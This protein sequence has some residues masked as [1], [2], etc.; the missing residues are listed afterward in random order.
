MLGEEA[1]GKRGLG[2]CS[3][4]RALTCPCA[5]AGWRGGGAQGGGR[6]ARHL[7]GLRGAS[8][9]CSERCLAV[10]AARMAAVKC[11]LSPEKCFPGF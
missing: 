6:S 3:E 4:A 9:S 2:R 10:G 5:A 11:P 7:L 8:A 1:A